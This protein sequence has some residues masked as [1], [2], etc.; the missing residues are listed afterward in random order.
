[1]R[2]YRI[3]A[4]SEQ[5]G[6]PAATLRAWERRYGVP[7]PA[8]TASAYRLYGDADVEVI[9]TM[10]DL[11]QGGM[12]PAE[13]A[14]LVLAQR[15]AQGVGEGEDED[16]YTS[17][18]N[19]IVEATHAFDPDALLLELGRALALGPAVS[20]FERTIGPALTRI[21][22]LWHAGKIT[23]AHEHLASQTIAGTL[24]DLLRLTQPVDGARRVVLACFAEEDHQLGLYG[25]ALR[26]AA[27]GFRG[28][29]IGAR[30]PPAALGRVVESIRPDLVALSVTVPPEPPR[31][32]ELV[33]AYADACR[34][35]VW[36]VGGK[37]SEEVRPWVDARGGLVAEKSMSTLRRQ[38][39]RAVTEQ[40]RAG[41]R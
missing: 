14:R 26:F 40:K 33:D 34:G 35:T 10:R 41:K 13:A 5:L 24:N 6:V 7:S 28:V 29:M 23:I 20:I 18:C 22:D 32:R 39:E 16:A 15:P 9:R 27:W 19:R 21:G 11:V 8:R 1:M 12:A 25:V 2:S 3:Q 36:V 17:A 31:A 37:A 4:V 38:V 30:T